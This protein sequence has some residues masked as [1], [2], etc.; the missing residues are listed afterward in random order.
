M[1]RWSVLVALIVGTVLLTGSV[2]ALAADDEPE[3]DRLP[4]LWTT[5][6]AWLVPIG[7]GLLACGAA[8]PRRVASV[9]RTGWL[10]LGV[11]VIGYWLCGF[12]FQFGG[13]GFVFDHPDLA[14]LVR[15]WTWSPLGAMWGTKW[16]VLGL[17]GYMLRGPASTP[18]ALSL[19]FS[20]LPWITTAVA[21]P[22]WSLQGRTSPITLFLSG[23]LVAFVYTLIGNWTHGGG[24]LANLGLNL[25]LGHGFVDF[26]GASAVHLAGMATALAGMLA[27]GR[28]A[29]IRSPVEQLF[30]PTFGAR[31]A[32][33]ALRWTPDD[34]PYVPMPPLYL[35]ALATLGAWLTIV[36]WIGWGLGTPAHVADGLEIA[37][38][39]MLIALILAAG[40]GAMTALTFSWLTTGQ[41]N[42]LMTARGVL[43][44]LVAVS[45]GLPFVPFWAALA[46]GAG[47]GVLVPL[48]HY[49]V[50][51][52]L[53]VDDPTSVVATHGVPALWGLLAVGLFAD[54]HAGQGWNQIGTDVY[55]GVSGQGV[56]G[57]WAAQ[58]Y[59][60]DWPGQFRAQATGGVAVF[61]TAFFLSW[62]LF[63]TVQGLTRA[64]QGEHAIRLPKRRRPKR[65]PSRTPKP[66]PP[67]A[68]FV[69]TTESKPQPEAEETRPLKAAPPRLRP[70]R[71]TLT[72][73]W[74]RGTEGTRS[75]VSRKRGLRRRPDVEKVQEAEDS[76]P[77]G[78]GES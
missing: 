27:F 61:V 60:S 16:G 48:V 19:F 34:E 77:D 55:L 17:E 31:R 5:A 11:S 45:G 9:I 29:F 76:T 24:W 62:L 8:P 44:A 22:L 57:Y 36:G 15:E 2:P 47:A 66:R 1:V 41:G 21:I 14:G 74:R 13:S 50:E 75:S 58:G 3:A 49:A 59:A 28:R 69:S 64:W 67:R 68:R 20:Q 71:N 40:G 12:A 43:G 37:W 53:R 63:A 10:A 23:V 46:V 56:A 51:H 25:G 32:D 6:L 39:E 72:S 4:P 35:P 73:W 70:C 33:P 42:A 52:L 30:L 7:L 78:N 54:G 18:A 26:A 65:R 38:T